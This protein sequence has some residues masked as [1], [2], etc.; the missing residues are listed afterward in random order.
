M[1]EPFAQRERRSF[2]LPI[3]LALV[4]LAV[5]AAIVIHL[6]PAATV[7]ATH[8]R[9]VLLP[10]DTVFKSQSIVVGMNRTE[11]VLYIASTISVDNKL[12]VPI[13]LEDFSLTF[14]NPD[15]AQLTAKAVPKAD[16][17]NLELTYPDLKPLLTNPLATDT[18]IDPAKSAQGTLLFALNI[19]PSMWDRR[20]SAVIQIS[21][22][23]QPPASVTIPI[24]NN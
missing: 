18:S 6:F 12:R 11:H 23:H 16:L 1:P 24:T 7:Q 3:V 20:K 22:Y 13:T 2:V 9:T 14:T 8:I 4:A 17:A 21:L 10:K 19:P 15:D 5:T